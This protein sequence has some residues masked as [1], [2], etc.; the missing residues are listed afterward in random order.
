MT[1][2]YTHLDVYKRQTLYSVTVKNCF[3]YGLVVNGATATATRL[4]TDGNGWGGVNV[5]KGNS[6][7][8][9]PSFTLK[10]GTLNEA[11]PVPVSYTHLTLPLRLNLFFIEFSNCKKECLNIKKNKLSRAKFYIKKSNMVHI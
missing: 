4:T 8:S 9:E 7:T 10:S 6:I 11:V 2:S 3:G 5:T 1:V